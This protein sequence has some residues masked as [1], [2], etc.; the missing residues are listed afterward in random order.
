M[1]KWKAT[2]HMA[3]GDTEVLFSRR[4]KLV[5]FADL[6][7]VVRRFWLSAILGQLDEN[8][9]AINPVF[10]ATKNKYVPAVKKYKHVGRDM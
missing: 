8:W 6:P 4:L 5:D 3:V 2:K 7:C 1:K 9:E 10:S